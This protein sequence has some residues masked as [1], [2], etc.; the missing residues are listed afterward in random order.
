MAQRWRSRLLTGR[1][2]VRIL[3]SSPQ[4]KMDIKFCKDE[5]KELADKYSLVMNDTKCKP[6]QY[7]LTC[8]YMLEAMN[9]VVYGN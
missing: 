5:C 4:C 7:Y 6:C 1:L 8:P 2:Q 9:D 3:L